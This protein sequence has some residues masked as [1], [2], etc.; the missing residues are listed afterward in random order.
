MRPAFSIPLAPPARK[1]GAQTCTSF[2]VCFSFGLG[3]HAATFMQGTARDRRRMTAKGRRWDVGGNQIPL[4]LYKYRHLET[5]DPSHEAR[6]AILS[7]ARDLLVH[8]QVWVASTD[9]LNDLHDMRFNVEQSSDPKV[10]DRWLAANAHLLRH[11][12]PARRIALCE[13]LRRRK[14]RPSDID[15]LRAS[16]EKAMGVFCASQDPRNEPMWAH[17]A[18]DHKGFSVQLDTS[19]DELFLLAEKAIYTSTFPTITLPHADWRESIR[20]HLSKS[21]AWSYEREWRVVIPQNNFGVR[22][23]PDAIAGVILGA[24]ASERTRDVIHAFNRERK[25]AGHRPFDVYQSRQHR[26]RFGMCITKAKT[27]MSLH[28]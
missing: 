14:L 19:Q 12:P 17:Y 23:R 7:R 3:A 25:N 15:D 28:S 6:D 4:Y 1:G 5:D 27:D 8:G 20:G 10:I 13:A 18:A 11:I 24:K 21:T 9:S 22:L 2:D 26:D 16:L